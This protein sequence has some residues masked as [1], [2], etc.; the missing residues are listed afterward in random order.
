MFQNGYKSWSERFLETLYN[1]LI[2]KYERTETEGE[3]GEEEGGGERR[4]S[5]AVC[6]CVSDVVKHVLQFLHKMAEIQVREREREKERNTMYMEEIDYMYMY[7][8]VLIL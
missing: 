7:I 4:H 3:E 8:L 6:Q 5:V 1:I 2:K